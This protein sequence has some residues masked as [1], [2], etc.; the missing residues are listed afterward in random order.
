VRTAERAGMPIP[1]EAA[2]KLVA[3]AQNLQPSAC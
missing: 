2:E 1:R 3:L